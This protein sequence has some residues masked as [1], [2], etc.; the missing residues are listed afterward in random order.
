MVVY[1]DW[2]E[3]APREAGPSP[4]SGLRFTAERRAVGGGRSRAAQPQNPASD[5][6]MLE[7][8]LP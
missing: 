6:T 7:N 8:L 3:M 5:T 1:L 4:E 2:V